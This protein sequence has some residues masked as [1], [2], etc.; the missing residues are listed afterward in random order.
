MLMRYWSEFLMFADDIA[1]LAAVAF[2]SA[3]IRSALVTYVAGCDGAGA[4]CPAAGSHRPVNIAAATKNRL[5]REGIFIARLYFR[6]TP[7]RNRT[8]RCIGLPPVSCFVA[9]AASVS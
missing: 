2:W 8:E 3:A 6:T 5:N 1:G 4:C 9:W 7:I